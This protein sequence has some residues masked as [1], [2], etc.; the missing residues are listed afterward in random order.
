MARPRL[1]RKRIGA[2]VDLSELEFDPD[3]GEA[4]GAALLA[5]DLNPPF[6]P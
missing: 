6:L 2:G 4:N 3:T 5:E 1:A